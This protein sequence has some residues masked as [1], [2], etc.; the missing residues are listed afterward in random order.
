LF[1][2]HDISQANSKRR[3]AEVKA[4]QKLHELFPNFCGPPKEPK[5]LESGKNML[6]VNFLRA[7]GAVLCSSTDKELRRHQELEAYYRSRFF[8]RLRFSTR[9][10]SS[11]RRRR[12]ITSTVAGKHGENQ[13]KICDRRRWKTCALMRPWCKEEFELLDELG[14]APLTPERLDPPM[15]TEDVESPMLK[16]MAKRRRL[17]QDNVPAFSHSCEEVTEKPPGGHI[18]K[19]ATEKQHIGDIDAFLD[20]ATFEASYQTEQQRLL[21]GFCEESRRTSTNLFRHLDQFFE[22]FGY[23]HERRQLCLATTSSSASLIVD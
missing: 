19:E 21:Q 7:G 1:N 22:E 15:V 3:E 16:P 9:R 4:A 11:L 6:C 13:S 23:P 8:R 18:C 10:S 12:L 5:G 2:P 14:L 20:P 17:F